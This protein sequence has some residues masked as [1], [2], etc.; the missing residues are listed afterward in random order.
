[1]RIPFSFRLITSV[2]IIEV[3]MLIILVWNNSRLT[4]QSYSD[5]LET[6]SRNQSQLLASAIAP[7]LI[8]YDRATVEDSLSQLKEKHDLLYAIVTDMDGNKIASIG[9]DINIENFSTKEKYREALNKEQMN[10]SRVVEAFGQNVGV[11]HMGFSTAHLRNVV[12]E[13][14]YQNL[15]IS[16]FTLL[17]LIAATVI[18]SIAITRKLVTLRHGVEQ[19]QKGN[20]E[21][22]IIIKRND[23]VGDLARAFNKM[24]SHLESTQQELIREHSE[25]E[26]QTSHL[27]TLLN[28]IDAVIWE[29][30]S[31][32]KKLSFVSNEA[33]DL[34]GYEHDRWLDS[35]FLPEI[36]H[37]D[38]KASL[39]NTLNKFFTCNDQ[40]SIDIRFINS[41]GNIVWTRIIASSKYDDE[42]NSYIIRGLIIDISNEKKR[43]QQIV[44]LAE[45]DSLT[46]LINRR[47]FQERLTHHIAYGERY[48]HESCLLF[49]DLDQFKYIN[50]TFG[51]A[52]GDA[53]LIQVADVL[54]HTIR[55]TDILGRLGGDEFG[56][57]LPFTQEEEAALVS[58]NLLTALSE[59]S[60]LYQGASVMIRASI[61]I[62]RFPS[63]SKTPS[64][65]L[66]EADTAM[67][68]AKALG[69]NRYHIYR[70]H[71]SEQKK[72][73]EKLE[74]EGL[75]RD[76]LNNDL[77]QLHFQPIFNFTENRITHHEALL[78]IVKDSGEII[79]PGAF[80]DT[81][82]RFG[83][84]ADIDRWTFTKVISI[85]NDSIKNNNPKDIA[86]NLSGNHID[87]EKF[88]KWIKELFSNHP[89]AI[90]H[91]II[92]ITET[93][94][95][96]NLMSAIAFIESMQE[97]GARFAIDDFGVGF[98]SF[99][100]LKNIPVQYIKIDG[101]FVVNLDNDETDRVFVRATVDI[102]KSLNIHTIAEYVENEEI[103]KVLK[104]IGADY[105]QGYHLGK[106]SA[107]FAD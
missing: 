82:E 22:E 11:L 7:G 70:E 73:H 83:L 49:I 78:R 72:M 34:L 98:S 25:L 95:I 3:V 37:K 58:A 29:A 6:S 106:P 45:H 102:A 24:A 17:A 38:D 63:A 81:A 39:E 12:D 75:I 43:E 18:I 9:D 35:D 59:K 40:A 97:M 56:V 4:N 2:V 99:H 20:L 8:A 79:M 47:Q 103:V 107:D 10:I 60:W 66:A 67:Y 88:H 1:M 90:P 85:I 76:A 46:G 80:I 31:N 48:G 92:E 15:L 62:T 87:D 13:I 100:Y 26:R 54:S 74:S 27:N 71:D 96:N 91:I 14:R 44:F 93:A 23:E 33:V 53:Y 30:S 84:I 68:A 51:H 32:T 52:A 55:D 89:D 19:I 77:F 101:S 64:V 42:S 28:G 69:R 61:G 57:I 104:S 94:A 65:L 50:D 86:V 41:T 36:V 105:G 21:H 16:L 5:L